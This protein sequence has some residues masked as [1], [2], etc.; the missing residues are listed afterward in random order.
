MI[1]W[2]IKKLMKS[3]STMVGSLIFILLCIFISFVNPVL[4][5]ENAYIDK[6]NNYIV[7]SYE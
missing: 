1:V 4:E 2:E 5:T 6:N 3:K 7:D